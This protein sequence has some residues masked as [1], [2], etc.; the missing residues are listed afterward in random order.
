MA[1]KKKSLKIETHIKGT[2]GGPS[3][4]SKGLVL[5]ELESRFLRV[6]GAI[7]VSGDVQVEELGF[8]AATVRFLTLK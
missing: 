3:H 4:V 1:V 6:F 2:G 7:M 5:T 8:G